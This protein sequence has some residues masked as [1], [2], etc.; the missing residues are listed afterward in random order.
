MLQYRLETQNSVHFSVFVKAQSWT[1]FWFLVFHKN[2]NIILSPFV[3]DLKVQSNL[4]GS[5]DQKSQPVYGW[6]W[7]GCNGG[8]ARRNLI[9]M[10]WTQTDRD[11]NRYLPRAPYVI[12]YFYFLCFPKLWFITH[13]CN[14]K[15][16]TRNNKWFIFIPC[17]EL[18]AFI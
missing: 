15:E 2:C 6:Q 13:D 1:D 16:I 9:S 17:F 10:P 3:R 5:S 18:L 7:M 12:S 14:I 11:I 4:L 8:G